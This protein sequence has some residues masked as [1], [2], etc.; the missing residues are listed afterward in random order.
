MSS[1][2][3]VTTVRVTPTETT[4]HLLWKEPVCNGSKILSYNIDIGDSRQLISVDGSMLEYMVT[5]LVPETTYKLVCYEL[6][7]INFAMY[8]H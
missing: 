3:A 7:L 6:R 8:L 1:P 4:I 5:D 2:G